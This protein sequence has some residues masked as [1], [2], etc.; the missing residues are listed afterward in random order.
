ME[1]QTLSGGFASPTV[2]V[3]LLDPAEKHFRIPGAKGQLQLFLRYLAPGKISAA[4]RIVLYIHGATFPSALSIAHRFQGRSWRDELCAAGFHVWGLDFQGFGASDR[5][6]EMSAALTQAPALGRA[7]EASQQIELAVLFINRFHKS[8]KVSLIAHSW[9]SIAAGHF[10]GQHPDLVDRMVFFGPISRRMGDGA[11]LQ[12][13][14]AWRLI[15]LPAQWGRFTED[16]PAGE[17][18]I[19]SQVDFD[20]WGESYL[21]TDPQSRLREPASV[22]VP[23]GPIQDIDAAWHGDLAYD[24]SR[25]SAPVAIVRGEW[26]QTSNDADAGWLFSALSSAPVKRDIKI[27]RGTH[28]MHLESSRYALYREAETFLLARDEPVSNYRRAGHNSSKG[29][30]LCL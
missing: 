5:Y 12:T 15:T 19:L 23:S 17:P 18:P 26:D 10:A 28:L 29:L 2:S 20:D 16:V 30:I 11:E 13:F 25:I 24:P 6:P 1:R 14:P 3:P 27:S 9:G 8:R 4:D 21:D 7:A 22:K